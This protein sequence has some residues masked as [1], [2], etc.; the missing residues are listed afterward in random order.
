MDR[1]PFVADELAKLADLHDRGVLTDEEFASQKAWPQKP[2]SR[3]GASNSSNQVRCSAAPETQS[4]ASTA[5]C[6]V[7][8]GYRHSGNRCGSCYG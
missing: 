2:K 6:P 1:E 3:S 4:H 8:S 5:R 7:G